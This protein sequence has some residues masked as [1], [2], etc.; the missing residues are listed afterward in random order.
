MRLRVAQFLANFWHAERRS[1][2]A[3]DIGQHQSGERS[4]AIAD[5]RTIQFR[6]RC[7]G[8]LFLD[9][10]LVYHPGWE[11]EHP[12]KAADRACACGRERQTPRPTSLP[13]HPFTPRTWAG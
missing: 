6:A 2:A 10:S 13:S 9:V 7:A 12:L 5:G 1:T 3:A 4:S 8:V 11:I